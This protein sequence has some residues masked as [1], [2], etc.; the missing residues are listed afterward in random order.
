ME[1]ATAAAGE[2]GAR[3]GAGA[4]REAMVSVARG[5]GAA[6]FVAERFA[7]TSYAPEEARR[8]L[9]V[10]LEQFTA[11]ASTRQFLRSTQAV[12]IAEPRN[13]LTVSYKTRLR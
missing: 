4:G 5:M 6:T 9:R 8:R 7:R 3:G 12:F 13:T 10:A 2:S 1:A 11:G